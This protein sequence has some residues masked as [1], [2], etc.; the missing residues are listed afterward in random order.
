MAHMEEKASRIK[1]RTSSKM[2]KVSVSG[3]L[4]FEVLFMGL[5]GQSMK[6]NVV[7]ILPHYVTPNF[8]KELHLFISPREV[9]WLS[10]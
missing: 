6:L 3:I 7:S 10:D 1:C 5:K 9:Q 2:T 4:F 8:L